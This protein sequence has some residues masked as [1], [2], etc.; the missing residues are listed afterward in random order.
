MVIKNNLLKSFDLNLKSLEF[1]FVEVTVLSFKTSSKVHFSEDVKIQYHNMV[2][3]NHTCR[4][5]LKVLATI[6]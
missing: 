3:S 2:L 5:L 4:G 6:I 1:K